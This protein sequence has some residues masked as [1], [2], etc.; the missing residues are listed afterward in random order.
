MQY[1]NRLTNLTTNLYKDFNTTLWSYRN[2]SASN[3]LP[4]L[5][6]DQ[7]D[8][9]NKTVNAAST[10]AK[11]QVDPKYQQSGEPAHPFAPAPFSCPC[12]PGHHR[13]S[14]IHYAA[15]RALLLACM[16]SPGGRACTCSIQMLHECLSGCSMRVDS[17]GM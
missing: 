13:A 11:R 14:L 17:P 1:E 7:W 10:K 16:S 5:P 4:L 9:L 12:L 8:T 6:P 15:A 3:V 2:A